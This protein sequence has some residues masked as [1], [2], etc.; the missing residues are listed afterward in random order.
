MKTLLIIILLIF[1]FG[2]AS[3]GSYAQAAPPDFATMSAA[4]FQTWQGNELLRLQSAQKR[5]ARQA[6]WNAQRARSRA[7][8]E[9]AARQAQSHHQRGLSACC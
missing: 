1:C 5:A 7:F 9:Q 6:S 3:V 8:M 4:E 2:C